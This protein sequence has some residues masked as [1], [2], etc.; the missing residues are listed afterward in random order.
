MRGM[1]QRVLRA[2]DPRSNSRDIAVF[3]IGCLAAVLFAVL[4]A[5]E[6]RDAAESVL[7]VLI[8]G[9][10]AVALV[11][12]L[13]SDRRKWNELTA[14][15]ILMVT[16]SSCVVAS[17]LTL[18]FAMPQ[19]MPSFRHDW[20]LP[21]DNFSARTVFGFISSAWTLQAFGEPKQFP[22]LYPVLAA[23]QFL[24]D[25]GGAKFALASIYLLIT[26]LSLGGMYVFLRGRLAASPFVCAMGAITYG[27]SPFVVDKTVAG[28]LHILLGYAVLPVAA[29]LQAVCASRNRI[30]AGTA[31]AWLGL[32]VALS[33][34]LSA[35]TYFVMVLAVLAFNALTLP[36]RR[37][38]LAAL[39]SAGLVA[40]LTCAQPLY[41]LIHDTAA[42]AQSAQPVGQSS[43]MWAAYLSTSM[44][45]AIGLLSYNPGYAREAFGTAAADVSAALGAMSLLFIAAAAA[46]KRCEAAVAAFIACALLFF[47]ITGVLGPLPGLKQFVFL[48]MPALAAF[49]EFYNF[50][51]PYLF[52]LVIATVAMLDASAGTVNKRLRLAYAVVGGTLALMSIVPFLSGAL[53]KEIPRWHEDASYEMFANHLANDASRIAFLPMINPIRIQG[54]NFGGTD[55]MFYGFYG[56]PVLSEWHAEPTIASAALLMRAG[57]VEHAFRLLGLFGVKWIVLRRGLYS[58]LP[59]YWFPSLF[60]SS[61]TSDRFYRKI[62]AF[63]PPAIRTPSLLAERNPWYIPILSLAPTPITCVGNAIFALVAGRCK[64]VTP[65]AAGD[66]VSLPAPRTYNPYLAWS[67]PYGTF[68]LGLGFA[69]TTHGVSTLGKEP[70]NV[71][72]QTRG[73]RL[74]IECVST[75]GV[76]VRVNG[77]V[78]QR[79]AC[80]AGRSARPMW[81]G[82]FGLRNSK[83]VIA[84]TNLGGASLVERAIL[85]SSLLSAESSTAFRF[86]KPCLPHGGC[87]FVSFQRLRATLL[88]GVFA[89][90]S[91]AVLVF[92]DSFNPNWALSIDGAR[93]ERSFRVNGFENGFSVPAGRHAFRLE[94]ETTVLDKALEI[95]GYGVWMFLMVSLLAL[96][97]GHLHSCWYRRER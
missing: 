42:T 89:S 79:R 21:V 10:G 55:P 93:A 33:L 71:H 25:F 96:A 19:G 97:A 65:I 70:L 2:I 27:L 5:L 81:A 1:L 53:E 23:F 39:A 8:G 85:A 44:T 34:A 37:A 95:E 47:G 63:E 80:A 88:R 62:T 41:H 38:A 75:R 94:Y 54:R 7:D 66:Q 92:S 50:E 16:V 67:D 69:S 86:S 72:V 43:I 24:S 3:W 60:P 82:P 18:W 13:R 4:E 32:A 15:E 35:I 58:D 36:S 61:W 49:R 14:R 30:E 64:A 17:L 9:F 56:H 52:V 84:L 12:V 29:S 26:A 90:T 78:V 59:N 51:G 40:T 46:S 31:S 48:K 20:T 28:H 45:K 74:Y 11:R 83:N 73:S 68:S 6:L 57:R 22:T 77:S 91:R 76:L 87:G